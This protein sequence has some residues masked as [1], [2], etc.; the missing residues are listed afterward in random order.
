MEFIRTTYKRGDMFIIPVN[1]S[2]MY[3]EAVYLEGFKPSDS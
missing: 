3:V 2:I 1:N